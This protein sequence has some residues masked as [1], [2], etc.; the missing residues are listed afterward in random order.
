MRALPLLPIRRGQRD[1]FLDERWTIQSET[2]HNPYEH[3]L[4]SDQACW[5]VLALGVAALTCVPTKSLL[6]IMVLDLVK[7]VAICICCIVRGLAY[8]GRLLA[9]QDLWFIY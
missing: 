6:A 8:T 9:V 3:Y 5:S 1:S 2:S 7:S 4:Y